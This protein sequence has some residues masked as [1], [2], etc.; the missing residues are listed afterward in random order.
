M[1]ND[2]ARLLELERE[3][4]RF[5]SDILKRIFG[6]TTY[7]SR[8]AASKVTTEILTG[9]TFCLKT[10][11]WVISASDRTNNDG[12]VT[13]HLNQRLCSPDVPAPALFGIAPLVATPI[14]DRPVML[15]VT[16][17]TQPA[18]VDSSFVPIE[19][20]N[21]DHHSGLWEADNWRYDPR[22]ML[23]IRVTVRSWAPDGSPAPSIDFNWTCTV[24]AAR[25]VSI[26]G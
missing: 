4:V 1:A 5:P 25:L 23:D 21:S 12:Q 20:W 11:T 10:A 9:T 16:H 14:G 3:L 18:N 22:D 6:R 2:T 19:I 26:G 13:I 15:T 8:M 17:Q 24:Q 7:V